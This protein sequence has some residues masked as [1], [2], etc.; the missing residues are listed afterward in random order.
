MP[1]RAHGTSAASFKAQY[2][3]VLDQRQRQFNEHFANAELVALHRSAHVRLLEIEKIYSLVQARREY[4]LLELAYK[5]LADGLCQLACANY[6]LAFFGL[7]S[8]LELSTAAV[9]FSAHELELRE[10]EIGRRDILWSALVNTENGASVYGKAFATAF[11]PPLSEETRHY[12]GL[13]Q[14]T[15]RECSQYVHANPGS[16]SSGE[17]EPERSKFWFELFESAVTSVFFLFL[18]RYHSEIGSKIA[19]DAEAKAI[20]LSEVGHFV[21]VSN[22]IETGVVQ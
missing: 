11:F 21:G 6:T 19:S 17:I 16:H 2:Q 14:R 1:P 4:R 18:V 13:A 5:L 20:F 22:A 10:W 3:A 8:F 15:Y 12:H 7:R 9:K